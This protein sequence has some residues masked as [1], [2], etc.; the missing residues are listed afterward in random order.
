MQELLL[1]LAK[2]A[3]LIILFYGV[4]QV[5]LRNDT[6]FQAN[7]HFLL[8][9]ILTAAVLPAVEFVRYVSVPMTFL[10]TPLSVGTQ[11][12]ENLSLL[13]LD[14][15]WWE[16]AG[17]VYAAVTGV[18]LL[19]LV[20]QLYSLSRI[21]RKGSLKRD[22]RFKIIRTDQELSP[23]SFFQYIVWN[24][25]MHA[26]EDLNNI[27]EHEKTHAS[28]WHSVD[29][30]LVNLACVVLWFNPLSWRYRKSLL[31]NLE[32]IA[33]RQTV[34]VVSKFEYQQTL[35]KLAITNNQP[36]LANNFYQSLIKKRILMLNKN[37]KKR[38]SLWKFGTIVPLLLA[39]MFFFNLR[40]E[41][42]VSQSQ[43]T[44][45]DAYSSLQQDN[46][47]VVL[48]GKV[49]DT[50]FKVKSIDPN[51]I[52]TVNVLKGD[53]AEEIYGSQA[54]KDGVIEI[55]TKE[56]AKDSEKQAD[57]TSESE[58]IIIIR[59]GEKG[60]T[61][62]IRGVSSEMGPK[63]QPVYV[64][65]GKVMK[66]GFDLNS[67]DNTNIESINVLKDGKAIAKYGQKAQDGVIEINTKD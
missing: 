10:E 15:I 39:F 50:D 27:L 52:A 16:V 13:S 62:D 31:Q 53:F 17:G 8:A 18:L 12:N 32:Y 42:Q 61:I 30:L 66:A 40:T 2:S 57:Q 14:N 49:M 33:D 26:K 1:Y 60:E 51:D 22:G 20:L 3:A 65:N 28:Q 56:F 55:V 63:P 48:N 25:T 41:A 46:P 58:R 21:I 47:L 67:V 24:P 34:S 6:S 19:R 35:V 38:T 45:E 23:F 11:N 4:Y 9:G 5:L 59:K 37:S 54:S 64:L 29:V 44:S 36:T 7:R 43:N